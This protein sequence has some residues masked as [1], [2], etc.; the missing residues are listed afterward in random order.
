MQSILVVGFNVRPLAR[1]AKKAGYRVLAVDFWGDHD[2]S[3]WTDEQIAILDQQPNQR[4]DRPKLPTAD[5]LLMG[6]QQILET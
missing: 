5:A 1:S 2:L 3:Q 6:V 4:P